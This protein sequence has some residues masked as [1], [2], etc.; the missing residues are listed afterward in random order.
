MVV[1]RY[2]SGLAEK[3]SDNRRENAKI[4]SDYWSSVV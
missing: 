3:Y 2:H 4:S 1:S